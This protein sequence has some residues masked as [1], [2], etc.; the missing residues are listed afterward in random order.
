MKNA[1]IQYKASLLIA[2]ST[3]SIVLSMLYSFYISQ[4]ITNRYFPLVNAAME[5]KLEATTAH[6]WFEEM[7]SGDRSIDITNVWQ[8]IDQAQ[9]YA[10]AMLDGGSNSEGYY[11]PLKNPE[12]RLYITRTIEHIHTFRKLAYQRWEFKDTSIV[13]SA[14]DQKFDLVFNQFLN[15]ANKVETALQ[16]IIQ[17][18]IKTFHFEQ[19]LLMVII[20]CLGIFFGIILHRHEKSQ[21][22]NIKLLQYREENLRITFNAIGEGIIVTDKDSNITYLNPVAEELTGWSHHQAKNELFTNVF[23]ILHSNSSKPIDNIVT[24]VI[25]TKNKV[26]FTNQVILQTKNTVKYQINISAFPILST[27]GKITG[28]VIIFRNQTKEN[29]LHAELKSKELLFST[30]LQSIPD[31]IWYKDK[32]GIYQFCNLQFGKFIGVA[33]SGIIG[34]TDFDLVDEKIATSF[35]ATDTLA[36]NTGKAVINEEQATSAETNKKEYFETKKSPIYNLKNELTGVLGIA[37]SITERKKQQNQLLNMA[38]YDILTGLPNRSLYIDRFHQA[39]V[40]S[41]QTKKKL[42]ICFLDL[43][44]FKPVNDKYGHEVGDELL[45]KVAQ[46]IQSCIREEDTLSRQGGDEFTMLLND[47]ESLDHVEQTLKR[48]HKSLAQPFITKNYQHLITASSGITLYPHDNNDIDTLIRHADQAMYQ[49]KLLGRDRFHFYNK[50]LDYATVQKHIKLDEIANALTNNEFELYYQPKV[51]MKTGV[52]YGVE[53]L[54]RWNHPE[55]GLTNPLNFLPLIEATLLENKIGHWVIQNAL[56]QLNNWNKQNI[57]VE[58]S[59]NISSYH[60]QSPSFIEELK[61]SLELYPNIHHKNIQLEILESSALGEISLISKIL[62][63]CKELCGIKIALDDFGTGYSSLTHL[64]NLPVETIKIDQ[65]FVRGILDNPNDFS[66]T[67]SVIKLS[68]S[69][70]REVIAEGVETIDHGLMLIAMGCIYAQGYIIAKPMPASQFPHWF[71]N[72]KPNRKWIGSAN[73]QYSDKQNQIES[74][75]LLITR[76]QQEFEK[77]LDSS[78]SKNSLASVLNSNKC[79]CGLWLKRVSQENLFDNALLIQLNNAHSNMHTIANILYN[80][81]QNNN[82]NDKTNNLEEF[83]SIKHN[84]NNILD[85]MGK[86][87]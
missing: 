10:Q 59:I 73:N 33:E 19:I 79:Y 52:V 8:N 39:I 58:L 2:I 47:I 34:K 54:I 46:R 61:T 16:Q 40:H 5:I 20:S 32:D 44:D 42:A 80:D 78:D 22:E 65:A 72:Y 75:K 3:I 57:N 86:L 74:L 45:I 48:I 18:K 67:D 85:K 51:N 83:K 21:D 69:F 7:I 64:R 82:S 66:I 35:Q 30:L 77:H 36:M 71:L 63:D 23:H 27:A 55:N 87:L 28:V 41:N 26:T 1:L 24:K 25:K 31:L 81:K 15:S 29:E 14:I 56:K 12:L 13:G 60:L 11:L 4:N 76:W 43:D 9:W 49:A 50:E 84:I 70:N 62:N 53:A 37:R 68:N 17:S 6:L 38:H